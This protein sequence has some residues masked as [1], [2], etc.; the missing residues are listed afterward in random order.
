MPRFEYRDG[1][2]AKFWTITLQERI[3]TVQFGRIGTQGQTHRKEFADEAAARKEHDKLIAEKL[4]KGYVEIATAPSSPLRDALE[5]AL[6]ANPD[7]RASHSAYADWL[8]DQG[9]SRGELIATQLALEDESLR[10]ARREKLR[11]RERQLLASH[12][13]ELVGDLVPFLLDK[14]NVEFQ[15]ARG[16]LN[17]LRIQRLNEDFAQALAQAPQTRL[18][19]SLFIDDTHWDDESE[20]GEEDLPVKDE[21]HRVMYRLGQSEYLGNLTVLRLGE[22]VDVDHNEQLCV[23]CSCRGYLPLVSRLPRLEELYLLFRADDLADLFAMPTLKHLRVLQLYHQHAYP[24]EVLAANPAFRSLTTLLC[25]PA[26]YSGRA[27]CLTLEGLQA[28]CRSRHLRS[29]THLC[30]RL[31]EVGDAGCREIVK[32]GI[33]KRLTTLD[34]NLGSI[35]DEGARIL[36]GCRDLKHLKL[37]DLGRNQMTEEGIALLEATG[38]PLRAHDQHDDDEEDEW[39]CIGDIE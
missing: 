26:S 8:T 38:V 33:L 3:F 30:L 23:H 25:H 39:F 1:K 31:T 6:I 2:S 19:R 5:A 7:D 15:A 28:V 4:R 16:W 36:A 22:T 12:Q 9:D 17:S 37:L 35:T 14:K 32:S 10:G 34:L 20:L 24:L 13:A 11:E 18:L 29:L 21:Y 27:R